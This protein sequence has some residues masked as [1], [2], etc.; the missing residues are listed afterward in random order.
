[1]YLDGFRWISWISG[2]GGLAAYGGLWPPVAR[3]SWPL[4][5]RIGGL[6][7]RILEAWRL[8]GLEARTWIGVSGGWEGLVVLEACSGSVTLS[9]LEKVGIYIQR[10]A[11]NPATA[12]VVTIVLETQASSC[13]NRPQ[14]NPNKYAHRPSSD[15]KS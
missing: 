14:N 4:N 9:T 13:D 7:H 5:K 11:P 8:G 2:V 15:P 10:A 1:M 12:L 3:E 6:E